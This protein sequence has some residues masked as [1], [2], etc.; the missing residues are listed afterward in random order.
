MTALPRDRRFR[1]PQ[2]DCRH[3]EI[4]NFGA[5][6]GL[7]QSQKIGRRFHEVEWQKDRSNGRASC[8]HDPAHDTPA[9]RTDL[10]PIAGNDLQA[11]GVVRMHFKDRFRERGVELRVA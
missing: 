9:P 10:N 2:F 7:V 4:W 5:R 6:I 8:D 3:F 1:F 11:M